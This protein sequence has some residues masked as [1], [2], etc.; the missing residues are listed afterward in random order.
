MAKSSDSFNKKELEKKRRKK[1]EE[2]NER[3]AQRKADKVDAGPKR[4]EDMFSYVDE[5][6]NLSSTP[7][8]PS[9][10][11]SIKAEDIALGAA[12]RDPSLDHQPHNGRLKF[13]NTE[14]GYGFIVD[15]ESQESLFVHI[16]DMEEPLKEQDK[17]TFDVEKGPKGLQA[18]RVRLQ[19][20][21]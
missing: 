21:S 3:R 19:I 13:F 16:K 4:L 9:K 11:F 20:K 14:K 15:N 1:Q 5:N 18:V 6:G 12:F 10:K 8:D 2:K 7:P 17:V